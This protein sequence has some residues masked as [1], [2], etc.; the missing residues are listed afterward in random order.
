MLHVSVVCCFY[1]YGLS[2]VSSLFPVVDLSQSHQSR[3]KNLRFI[4]LCFVVFNGA[5]YQP[6]VFPTIFSVFHISFLIVVDFKLSAV[7]T[8]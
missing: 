4:Y 1:W 5:C 7:L 3:A 8:V 6:H 2:L